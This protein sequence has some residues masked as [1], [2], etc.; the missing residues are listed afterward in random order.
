MVTRTA[1]PLSLIIDDVYRWR[2]WLSAIL[3]ALAGLEFHVSD[4]DAADPVIW[5][6]FVLFAFL[7]IPILV[8]WTRAARDAG[9]AFREG[10]DGR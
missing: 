10:L 9:K 8:R 1:R 3:T 7:W 6:F 2:W 5:V 4:R